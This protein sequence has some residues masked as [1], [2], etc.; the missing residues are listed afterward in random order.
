[1]IVSESTVPSAATSLD[2]HGSLPDG[3]DGS[4]SENNGQHLG[5]NSNGGKEHADH[6]VED[7]DEPSPF[8]RRKISNASAY[9]VHR[10]EGDLSMDVGTPPRG[11]SVL[12]LTQSVSSEDRGLD[13]E[14]PPEGE[15][16]VVTVK[17]SRR[18]N[19]DGNGV[20]VGSHD[21]YVGSN[22]VGINSQKRKSISNC[23][24]QSKGRIRRLTAR[25][26]RRSGGETANAAVRT[27]NVNGGSVVNYG[28]D[29]YA[30]RSRDEN[31]T[32]NERG[33][34]TSTLRE[35]HG[36]K[37]AKEGVGR[38]AKQAIE[39]HSDGS[40]DS[41]R[42]EKGEAHG[43]VNRRKWSN[44][45][46]VGGMSDSAT[47]SVHRSNNGRGGTTF[48]GAPSASVASEKSHRSE[49]QPLGLTLPLEHEKKEREGSPVIAPPLQPSSK[50][51]HL[52]NAKFT[53]HTTSVKPSHSDNVKNGPSSSVPI[54]NGTDINA[55][56]NTHAKKHSHGN[57]PNI[58]KTIGLVR[59][60]NHNS[61]ACSTAVARAK[62]IILPPH[63]HPHHPDY[64]LHKHDA[65]V[66]AVRTATTTSPNPNSNST[67]TNTNNHAAT[68]PRALFPGAIL[69]RNS[70]TSAKISH[71]VDLGIDVK[72]VGISRKHL[73]VLGVRG[74]NDRRGMDIG[75]GGRSGNDGASV[76]EG[77]NDGES[78]MCARSVA[79]NGGTASTGGGKSHGNG[80]A[81]V[82]S[83]SH[84][85]GRNGNRSLTPGV[86]V[87]VI[88]AAHSRN[89]T[90]GVNL[91][92]TRGGIRRDAYLGQGHKCTLR[93][94]D[95]IEFYSDPLIYFCVVELNIL[96]DGVEDKDGV[97]GRDGKTDGV[98]VGD[99]V[100]VGVGDLSGD[101]AEG[102]QRKTTVF[103]EE[104][105]ECDDMKESMDDRNHSQSEKEHIVAIDNAEA[106]RSENDKKS[107]P[108]VNSQTSLDR[109]ERGIT[110]NVGDEKWK[111]HRAKFPVASAPKESSTERVSSLHTAESMQDHGNGESNDADINQTNK[112]DASVLFQTTELVDADAEP[113]PTHDMPS[114]LLYENASS[115]EKGDNVR[116]ALIDTD[117]TGDERGEWYYG[118]V[119]SSQRVPGSSPANFNAKVEL[120][121]KSIVKV[122]FPDNEVQ[123]VTRTDLDKDPEEL[124][125]GDFVDCYYQNGGYKKGGWF[126]G[127][128]ACIS[129]D[130]SKCDVAYYDE[131]YEVN[132]PTKEKKIR[133][134]ERCDETGDWMLHKKALVPHG[135]GF[136]TGTVRSVTTVRGLPKKYENGYNTSRLCRIT[137]DD[138]MADGGESWDCEST[139]KFVFAHILAKCPSKFRRVWPIASTATVAESVRSRRRIQMKDE[140]ENQGAKSINVE[141]KSKKDDNQKLSSRKKKVGPKKRTKVKFEVEDQPVKSE[142]DGAVTTAV[143]KK[144][145]GEVSKSE[146]PN[147]K[148]RLS[149]DCHRVKFNEKDVAATE[150]KYFDSQDSAFRALFEN[151][152]KANDFHP[153]LPNMLWCALNSPEADTGACF[154]RDLLCVHD[155]VPPVS[156]VQKLLDLMKF[157]PKA[158][159]CKIHFKDP[160]RTELASE[161]V[162]SLLLASSRLVRRDGTA[163][164]GPSSFE[165]FSVLLSQSM[166]QTANMISGR[167]LAHGLHLSARGA[168]LLS[169]MLRTE[170]QDVDLSSTSFSYDTLSLKSK[171]TVS[172][173]LDH[174]RIHDVLKIAARNASTCLFRHSR[175]ILENHPLLDPPTASIID[176]SCCLYATECFDE[177]GSTICYIAWLFCAEEGI[178][179]DSDRC[180]YAIVNEFSSELQKYL[181]H[182]PEM[183][184]RAEKQYVKML[185]FRFL[186]SLA[187]EFARPLVRAIGNLFDMAADLSMIGI[188]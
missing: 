60:P 144:A 19:G 78:T 61:V 36:R 12:D 98:A 125:I 169:L 166:D 135:D 108:A 182:S 3:D 72:T 115:I 37:S 93:V 148:A 5:S 6:A 62:S 40:D 18:S 66:T 58:I 4:A 35:Y 142:N 16:L 164:F 69:G 1:M 154:L 145:N 14:C 41:D 163:L 112:N 120:D 126:R 64:E 17:R 132:I 88:N 25:R 99:G 91:Y 117:C 105:K 119:I 101:C 136:R 147:R 67:D 96:R 185:K 50:Y 134:I 97:V 10:R 157:G 94:G 100:E 45:G 162:Y 121:D 43:M 155:S 59:V 65:T 24:C 109:M 165:D 39:I 187:E 168:K 86:T 156:L 138:D 13:G 151:K 29:G 111:Q 73:R 118:K 2:G 49:T 44:I 84:L 129:E 110:T 180:A 46:C 27:A 55:S 81:S 54:P 26:P 33:A 188:W 52:S 123:K 48:G 8:K 104:E 149:S 150:D 51:T 130:G 68:P 173:I 172:L 7:P 92:R 82:N 11:A 171:P 74:W 106:T 141:T 70:S 140:A 22:N 90:N 56:N 128:V 95:A 174:P 160:H 30:T 85:H 131:S 167:R 139:A 124:H 133:L 183:S 23:D 87:E 63:C 152:K 75:R 143:S 47:I 9:S 83:D 178:E 71:F 15:I 181:D 146:T 32:L 122:E 159:G 57:N 184:E 53:S 161:Y 116:V 170:L 186:Q 153:T 77:T 20:G 137:F 175:W 107:S 31:G 113:K 158:D 79:S 76:V 177:L 28:V 42:D 176:E 89:G 179:L 114:V 21:K 127:R 34:A 103:D 80:D 38:T 102:R